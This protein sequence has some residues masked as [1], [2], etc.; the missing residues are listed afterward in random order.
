MA[1]AIGAHS[2][3]IAADES[4]IDKVESKL[5]RPEKMAELVDIFGSRLTHLTA[6]V[7]SSLVSNAAASKEVSLP[8]AEKDKETDKPPSKFV[9]VNMGGEDAVATQTANLLV[10]VHKWRTDGCPPKTLNQHLEMDVD[11]FANHA[12]AATTLK[13]RNKLDTA[14]GVK[15]KGKGKNKVEAC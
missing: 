12:F 15:T 4:E 2:P 11:K 8:L 14:S 5:P 7:A 6:A 3:L 1:L 9:T 10:A 13:F